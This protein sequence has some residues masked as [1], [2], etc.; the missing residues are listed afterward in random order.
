MKAAGPFQPDAEAVYLDQLRRLKAEFDNYR[1]RVDREKSEYYSLAKGKVIFG[2]LPVLDD[3]DRMVRYSRGM[4]GEF[5]AGIEL[6]FQKMRSILTSEGLEEIDPV[7]SPFDPEVHEALDL[8]EAGPE[9]DGLV[10][11]E[12]QRGYRLQGKLLRPSKVRVAR[13][14]EEHRPA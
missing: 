10:T 6:I 4:E 12:L 1:K 2:L 11:E 5:A 7:G 14:R 9:D 3:L 8:V 13:R